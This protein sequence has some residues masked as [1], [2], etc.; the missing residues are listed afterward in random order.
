[1]SL[2]LDARKKSRQEP[3]AQTKHAT[4]ADELR[5]EDHPSAAASTAPRTAAEIH[6]EEVAQAARQ[7]GQN[8][9]DAKVPAYTASTV[10]AF[11]NRNL[12]LALAGT[13]ILL[14]I[15]GAYLWYIDSGSSSTT[16][17]L[18]VNAPP[19]L[20]VPPPTQSEPAV[21]AAEPG[22]DLVSGIEPAPDEPV[23]QA[24]PVAP[25]GPA[26]FVEPPVR[27]RPPVRIEQQRVELVDPLLRDAYLAYRTG[28]LEESQQLYLAMSKKDAHNA[29]ALLGLAAIA[30][31]QDEKLVAAHY[32]SKV[33]VL[34]PRN[35]LA[36]A[37]MA[38]L[39]ADNDGNDETR[40]KNLLHEQ[41]DSAALH[42]ALGNLYAE[43]SRWGEAQQA[44]F[45]AY[46]LAPGNAEYAFN[47]A[48]SL[49]H[50]GQGKLATQY[51]RRAIELDQS[52][53][54]G[55]DHAQ[56]EQRIQALTH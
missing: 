6:A 16:P 9:F 3:S 5:L 50:L 24:E 28:K 55:F 54:P 56:V 10:H 52:G 18:P 36:N 13:V 27:P 20:P 21:V 26:T 17:L 41:G 44:Y 35:A 33:L 37:G 23:P 34:D 1:M 42:F 2:L 49:D 12:L 39:S 47:L 15:G 30:L 38:S 45:N 29:D 11:P 43:Q 4:T 53:N 32:F 48:V 22:T 25:P 14:G 40:L 8:L 51:Y 7:T 46:T 31:Q 19:M